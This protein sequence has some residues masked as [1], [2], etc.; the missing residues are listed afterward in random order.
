MQPIC[1][2]REGKTKVTLTCPICG[3][4]FERKIGD[5][6]DHNCC[7][8][9]CSNKLRPLLK[10]GHP[11]QKTCLLCGKA[12][13][14]RDKR[15]KY[16]SAACYWEARRRG[17][18]P[19]PGRVTVPCAYCGKPVERYKAHMRKAKH[20][21]CSK[22]CHLAWQSQSLKGKHTGKD[23]PAYNPQLE[24]KTLS[25]AYCGKE[26]TARG[27]K[28][29]RSNTPSKGYRRFCSRRC[30]TLYRNEH[31]TL[32]L[33]KCPV[34]GK[35]FKVLPHDAE[36]VTYCSP[37]C[38]GGALSKSMVGEGNFFHGKKHTPETLRKIALSS[39]I[40]SRQPT[41]LEKRVIQII[42]ANSLPFRY[43]G[44]GMF[45]IHTSYGKVNPDF[46][47][48]N[49]KLVVEVDGVYWHS[50]YPHDWRRTAIFK[51]AVYLL[52]GWKSLFLPEFL[53]DTEMLQELVNFATFDAR[54]HYF[55]L[56]ANPLELIRKKCPYCGKEFK[57]P[58]WQNGKKYCSIT[59]AVKARALKQKKRISVTCNYCGKPLEKVHSQVW[60]HNFCSRNCHHQ[61]QLENI[62]TVTCLN[63]GKDFKTHPTYIRQGRTFCSW[64][65]YR[66]WRGRRRVKSVCPVCGKEYCISP[67]ELKEGRTFCSKGCY[68][69]WQ[70]KRVVSL[71]VES[72]VN[73]KRGVYV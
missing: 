56:P 47:H 38:H 46:I 15:K 55:S 10:L 32:V 22:E 19:R 62:P 8:Y 50:I 33:K 70:R 5:V 42:K 9:A 35:E 65:C 41:T 21:F 39:P 31:R 59:C 63:C 1:A 71:R 16:C 17:F 51:E 36:K 29:Y 49:K 44:N 4:Q 30:M 34:C 28:L 7:S 60:K 11:L 37:K 48:Y 18:Y 67:H 23:S 25:C 54:K 68:T 6:T 24:E 13:F 73:D 43:T 53:S 58:Q 72:S 52:K 40:Y 20:T 66:K 61:W 12:F 64:D 14:T 2:S 57:V 69:T 3:K 45:W 27:V 26:H